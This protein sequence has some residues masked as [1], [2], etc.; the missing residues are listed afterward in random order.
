MKKI[1]VIAV[2]VMAA[3]AFAPGL[4]QASAAPLDDALAALVS[5]TAAQNPTVSALQQL[6]STP[7]GKTALVNLLTNAAMA[8]TGQTDTAGLAALGNSAEFRDAVT[9]VARQEVQQAVEEKLGPYKDSLA[10]LNQLF[11]NTGP[12]AKTENISAKVPFEYHKVI[13]MTATAY[14]PGMLDNGRWNDR[15]Y[16]G[17]SVRKGVVAVD[18]AV[19][20]LGTKVWIEGYG[21]AVA[22]DMGS[23]IKGDRIDLAFDSRQEAI[24]YGMKPVKVYI[25]NQ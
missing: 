18:P 8:R 21:A 15:T 11:Q 5:Q 13:D 23:A 4:P 6:A 22:E 17:G 7:E 19:I 24:N 25:L 10:L 20:P 3:T 12:D 14:A 9:S 1:A 16:L 2:A